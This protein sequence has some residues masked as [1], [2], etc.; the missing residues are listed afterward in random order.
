MCF[1]VWSTTGTRTAIFGHVE[2]DCGPGV[3]SSTTFLFLEKKI[4]SNIF[5][6]C[7]FLFLLFSFVQYAVYEHVLSN[8]A[9]IILLMFIALK[10]SQC[11][12]QS[13]PLRPLYR[14]LFSFLFVFLFFQ[15]GNKI[16][17][18]WKVQVV[19][20]YFRHEHSP[21][22]NHS[23]TNTPQCYWACFCGSIVNYGNKRQR[24]SHNK[25]LVRNRSLVGKEIIIMVTENECT[26]LS[27]VHNAA[28]SLIITYYSSVPLIVSRTHYIEDNT[29]S[30]L[31]VSK[32]NII[33]MITSHFLLIL[34]SPRAH[35]G[36]G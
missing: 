30:G 28:F 27:I 14:L 17:W 31:S 3:S 36:F 5:F 13:L 29:R 7:P 12:G 1:Y 26:H 25:L 6:Y 19:S 8:H 15:E 35:L 22:L 11:L 18:N 23:S 33:T 2:D 16:S 21:F 24:E 9:N 20:F 34:T 10:T 32:Y 4:P